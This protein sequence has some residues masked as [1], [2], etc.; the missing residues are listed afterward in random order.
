M[1][2]VG[3]WE[4][5]L[6]LIIAL[7]VVGPDRLP[8]LA[9]TV[10]RWVGKVRR[11]AQSVQRDIDRSIALEDQAKIRAQLDSIRKDAGDLKKTVSEALTEDV[12]KPLSEAPESTSP[13]PAEVGGKIDSGNT[14]DPENK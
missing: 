11:M 3:I 5:S 12:M 14:P 6:I 8:T 4:I 13:A 10:G 7:I 2:D 9:T 1:F